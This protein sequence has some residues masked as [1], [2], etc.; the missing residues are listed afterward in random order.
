[1]GP[2]ELEPTSRVDGHDPFCGS[3]AAPAP[4]RNTTAGGLDVGEQIRR[5]Q[6][7]AE[8]RAAGIVTDG[9]LTDLKRRVL[10]SG[11][12]APLEARHAETMQAPHT[13]GPG[14]AEASAARNGRLPTADTQGTGKT[15]TGVSYPGG[16]KEGEE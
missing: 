3:R 12:D 16:S 1:M 9:E 4:P 15:G 13:G 8:L 14:G 10:A 7:L 11:P 6:A 5:L 2:R